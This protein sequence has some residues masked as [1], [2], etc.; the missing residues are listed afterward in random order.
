MSEALTR[1]HTLLSSELEE[2]NAI[3]LKR[4][5][6]HIT[7]I[8]KV[9]KHIIDAGGKRLRPMLTLASAKLCGYNGKRHINLAACVEFIHT[10]TLLHDDVVDKSALRRGV[11]TANNL[12][13]NKSS[14]LVG[15]FLLGRSF[16]MMVADGSLETLTIL[17]DAS[18]IIAEGEIMQLSTTRN[19]ATTEA[20]YTE[21][22]TAKTAAL[23]AAACEVGAVASAASEERQNALREFGLNFGIAFQIVDDALDYSANPAKFGKSIGDDFREGK[24]TL[25]VILAYARS[26]AEDKKFWE[27]IITEENHANDNDL[28]RASEIIASTNAFN[29]TIKTAKKYADTA[30]AHLSIFSDSEEKTQL[31]ETLKFCVN[32]EF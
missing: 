25:P 7:L 6:N 27:R 10:A 11:A 9:S 23:F 5:E 16:Q 15:D 17:S 19:L 24:M 21:V 8:P 31:A 13:G 22:I 20:E 29:D 12:W 28:Q 4:L 14:V 3:I 1:L 18:A 32:R 30:L 26:T 2:V